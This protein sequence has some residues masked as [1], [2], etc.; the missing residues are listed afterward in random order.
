M[1]FIKNRNINRRGELAVLGLKLFFCI[2]LLFIISLTAIP[3]AKANELE[4][5]K[6]FLVDLSYDSSE[7]LEITATLKK[8]G[9]NAYFYVEDDYYNNLSRNSKL[10]FNSHLNSL[11]LDFD[12]TVYPKTREAFGYEWNPGIDN[13]SKITILFTKTKENIGGYFNPSDEYR[14]DEVAGERSNEREMVYLNISFIGDNR[15]KSFLAHEFQHM[16]TWYHKTKLRNITDDIWLNE[17]RSEYAS[18]AIGYDDDYM[19]SNLRARVKNFEID[20]VDS[21]TEWQN[22]IYDYSSVN[23]FSQYLADRFGKEIFKRMVDNNKVGIQSINKALSD[24]YYKNDT[25]QSVFK[26]WVITNY[27]N[28]TSLDSKY[29]YQNKNLNYENFHIQPKDVYEL[30]SVVTI[31]INDS[32]KDWSNGYYELDIAEKNCANENKIKI[33]FD[34]QDIGQF[35]VSYVISYEDGTKKIG[36]LNLDDKQNSDFYVSCSDRNISSVT[37]IPI[38]HKKTSGFG[39][40]I[41][42]YSFSISAEI[43]KSNK[44]KNDSLL[45]SLK[46]SRVYLIENENKRWITSPA[47]FISNGYKW[48]DIVIVTDLELELYPNGEN[49]KASFD[50][51]PDGSLIK[52]SSPEVY[53]IENENKRWITSPAVFIS[54]GYKW[55]DII[56]V[57][58]YELN[59]YSNGKDVTSSDFNFDKKLLKGSDPKVYLIENGNKRWITSA[60]VFISNGYKWEDIIIVTDYELG[61]YLKGE[62]VR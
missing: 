14:K 26:D 10:E 52:G 21:L 5:N 56:I 50:L 8:I 6:V 46:D 1:R 31:N 34:G 39:N 55:E 49:I 11:V 15:I 44:Y 32:I 51:K 16:I 2:V 4:E 3:S 19:G 40:N 45:K 12:N 29:S 42:K 18:T 59:S 20:P 27:I 47:V 22:K 17:A 23:L 37:I 36:E 33:N 28:G 58:D 38:S 57:T 41:N 60:D 7:R 53:L 24:L 13:D 43:A 25:F 48:E 54:N 9:V 61:L 35:S 62:N 30:N